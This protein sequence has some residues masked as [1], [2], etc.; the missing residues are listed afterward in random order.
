MNQISSE[1]NKNSDYIQL[2]N[3][4]GNIRNLH[5]GIDGEAS[6]WVCASNWYFMVYHQRHGMYCVGR[7]TY[8]VYSLTYDV[9]CPVQIFLLQILL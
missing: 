4:A 3:K 9:E 8:V 5:E 6:N 7:G 1:F 2:I